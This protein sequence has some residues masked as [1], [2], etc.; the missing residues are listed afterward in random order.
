MNQKRIKII[1]LTLATTLIIANIIDY[2]TFSRDAII[3]NGKTLN[4]QIA[5]NN[6][7]RSKGLSNI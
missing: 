6:Y 1:L 4:V 2:L 5:D 7:L 3:I